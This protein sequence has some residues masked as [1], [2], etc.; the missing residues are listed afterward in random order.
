MTDKPQTDKPVARIK[1]ELWIALMAVLISFST[2]FVY[3]YQSSL[4]KTQQKM[5]VWPHVT[6]SISRSLDLLTLDIVNKGVGPAIINNMRIEV[7]GKPV[8]GIAGLMDMVPDSLQS[9]YVYSSIYPGQV[10]MAGESVRIFENQHPPTIQC[11][12]EWMQGNKMNIKICY[13]SVYD[14]CW[15]SSGAEVSEG[16][17]E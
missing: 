16:D 14:D 3:V 13:C 6:L 9:A 4:M 5:S 10:L 2:L 8:D 17:C 11:L 12:L 15:S 7:D 1:A